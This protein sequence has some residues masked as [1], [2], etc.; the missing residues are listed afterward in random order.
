M[1]V[2][3]KEMYIWE[4]DND[5][6]MNVEGIPT[7]CDEFGHPY[8]VLGIKGKLSDMNDLLLGLFKSYSSIKPLGDSIKPRKVIFVWRQIPEEHVYHKR[9]SYDIYTDCRL[10]VYA[11]HK[12]LKY[13]KQLAEYKLLRGNNYTDAEESYQKMV[14]NDG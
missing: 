1:N 5:L 14:E 6:I 3:S 10:T 4:N 2:N 7:S 11:Y 13:K 8:E 9:K 12:Y